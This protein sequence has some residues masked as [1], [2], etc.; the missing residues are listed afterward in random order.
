MSVELIFKDPTTGIP[1]DLLTNPIYFG[2][3]QLRETKKIKV[4][5][6]NVDTSRNLL[7]PVVAAV[8]HPTAQFG[9]AENTYDACFMSITES[10]TFTN[11]LILGT[12]PPAGEQDIWIKWEIAND[13]LPGKGQFAMQV[14]G[15]YDL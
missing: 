3:L 10:G 6:K 11:P 15:E 14:T 8:V 2:E 7:T 5:L 9:P 13:A 12:M 4:I 1:Y